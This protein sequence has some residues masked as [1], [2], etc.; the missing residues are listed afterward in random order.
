MNYLPI[1]W[2]VLAIVFLLLFFISWFTTKKPLEQL[3]WFSGSRGGQFMKDDETGE[4]FKLETALYKAIR[5]SGYLNLAAFLLAALAA[6]LS[7]L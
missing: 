5:N 3:K 6:I 4:K 1:V 7:F 2:G